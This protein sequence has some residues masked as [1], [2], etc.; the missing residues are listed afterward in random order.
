MVDFIKKQW[1]VLLIGLVFLIGIGYYIVDKQSNV[2]KGKTVNGEAIVFSINDKNVTADEVYENAKEAYEANLAAL[3]YQIEIVDQTMELTDDEKTQAQITIQGLKANSEQQFGK[4]YK[5][6]LGSVLTAIGFDGY[7]DLEKFAGFTLKYNRM[8]KDFLKNNQDPYWT[9]LEKNLKPRLVSHIIVSIK[10]FENITAE[11]QK[12]MDDIKAALAKGDSFASVAQKYSQDGAAANGGSLGFN[13]AQSQLDQDFLKAMLELKQG[14]VSDWV[15][16]QFGYHLIKID[17]TDFDTIMST[18]ENAEQVLQ[19]VLNSNKDFIGKALQKQI[20]DNKLTVT[21][22]NDE[23]KE[24]ILRHYG[25]IQDETP[26]ETPVETPVE[27]PTETP[28]ETP[29]ET[30]AETET[31]GGTN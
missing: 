5:D 6:E 16:T 7:Q 18:T 15:K 29:V 20:D 23:I 12:L 13:H 4:N 22:A 8:L 21:F 17:A 19:T 2:V 1:F 28:A 14:E 3:R 31:D 24:A 30:P 11:E 9:T 25:L 10:D 27:T 26:T